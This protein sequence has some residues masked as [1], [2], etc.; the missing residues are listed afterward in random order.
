MN[1]VDK[2]ELKWG[3]S[4]SW[5]Y[6]YYDDYDRSFFWGYYFWILFCFFILFWFKSC[7]WS[8]F[9]VVIVVFGIVVVVGVVKKLRDRF[10]FKVCLV[11]CGGG[12][13]C[14]CFCSKFRF[15]WVVEIG[16]VV[17][18][19]GIVLKMWKNYWDK[20]V[21]EKECECLWFWGYYSSVDESDYYCG[22]RGGWGYSCSCSRSRFLVKFICCDFGVDCDLGLVEYGDMLFLLNCGYEDEVEEWRCCCRFC[23]RS[24]FFFVFEF[25]K[26]SKSRLR[27]MVVVGV[28]V[29]GVKEFVNC[30]DDDCRFCEREE[31]E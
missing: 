19:V 25:D 27:N 1:K 26:C 13:G 2:E 8:L 30:K 7:C 4:W 22:R 24:Y 6:S 12:N 3:W 23:D 17:V 29:I 31:C 5:C 21:E 11:F 16:G 15:C 28:V 20:K 14:S 9:C 10:K 18:M